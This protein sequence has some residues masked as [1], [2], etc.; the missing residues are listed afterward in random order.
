MPIRVRLNAEIGLLV[1][2][3]EGVVTAEEFEIQ[4][5]PLID[6]PAYSQVPLTLVDMTAALR[7]DGPAEI[8][9]RS[10]RR[11]EKSVDSDIEA[12]AKM[13][14]VATNDE[15]YGLGRMYEMLRDGS[16]LEIAVFRSLSEAE[17]WLGLPANFE[18]GLV[19]V[20]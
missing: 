6:I 7:G 5:A 4:V 18:N 12:G 10:A 8:V 19:D 11:A 16:P 13:A 9:R 14:L 20:V 3:F 17:E 15:F 2:V 1:V